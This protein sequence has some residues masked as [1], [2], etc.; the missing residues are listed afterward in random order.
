M[1]TDEEKEQILHSYERT[2]DKDMA[3]TK[4]GL[5]KEQRNYLECDQEFQFRIDYILIEQRELTIEKYK[6]FMLS[7]NDKIA[8]DATKEMAKFIYP[9][10]I[11]GIRKDESKKVIEL[12]DLDMKDKSDEELRELANLHKPIVVNK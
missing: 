9:D 12:A 7:V 4:L 8:F 11:D 5:S 1:V 10:F 2:F 3:Y 6:N